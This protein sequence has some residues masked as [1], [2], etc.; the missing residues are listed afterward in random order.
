[1]P[2]DKLWGG[3]WVGRDEGCG[4]VAIGCVMIVPKI[5][6]ISKKNVWKINVLSRSGHCF[7]IDARLSMPFSFCLV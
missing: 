7:C 4:D 2:V 3:A 5:G 1:M 6:W